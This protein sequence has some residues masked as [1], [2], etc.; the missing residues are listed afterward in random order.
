MNIQ[1][2]PEVVATVQRVSITNEQFE[3]NTEAVD[4]EI[5]EDED[6]N[7]T[8]KKENTEKTAEEESENVKN[9][10]DELDIPMD[11]APTLPPPVVR[12]IFKQKMFKSFFRHQKI[13]LHHL[14][15]PQVQITTRQV[16]DFQ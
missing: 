15:P 9:T 16:L 13:N 8:E 4:M 5:E 6:E 10:E 7:S 3:D 12:S 2:P 1:T 14:L 11:P